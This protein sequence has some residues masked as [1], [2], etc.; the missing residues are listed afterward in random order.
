MT[1]KEHS[2]TRQA[3]ATKTDHQDDS[4][5]ISDLADVVVHGGRA[6]ANRIPA[7]ADTARDALAGAQAQVNQLSDTGMVGALGFAVG[8]TAGVLVAGA[9]RLM[10]I[11]SAVPV[12]LTLRSAMTRDIRP[13]RL[14]N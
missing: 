11:M 4:S 13:A 5:P 14:V 2:M 10:V 6:V 9:P 1:T 3:L 7:A 8:V 12:A